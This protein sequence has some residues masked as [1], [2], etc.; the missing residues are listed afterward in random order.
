MG[1]AQVGEGAL[2]SMHFWFCRE[3]FWIVIS[4][5]FA[6]S[7]GMSAAMPWMKTRL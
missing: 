4:W 6:S 5:D 7:T 2:Q 3:D 1:D